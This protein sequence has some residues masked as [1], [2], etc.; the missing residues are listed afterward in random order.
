MIEGSVS[1]KMRNPPK[2]LLEEVDDDEVVVRIS[3][4]PLLSTEGSKLTDEILAVLAGVTRKAG[5]A[6]GGGDRD[7]DDGA[8][9]YPSRSNES[10]RY[11]LG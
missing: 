11:E 9:A 2:I 7:R 8:S 5:A 6:S 1:I 3:A 4:T 10:S